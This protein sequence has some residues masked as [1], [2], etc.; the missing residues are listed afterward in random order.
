MPSIHHHPDA[1]WH[2]WD[3]HKNTISVAVLHPG[4]EVPATDKISHDEPSV[5]RLIARCGDPRLLRVCYEPA[6][7]APPRGH[8]LLTG[9][10]VHCDVIAPSLIPK[11]PGDRVKTDKRD[12]RR[13]VRLYRAGELTAIRVPT[14]AEEAVRDLLLA[15][16]DL[17]ADR[18]RARQRLGSF[19]PRH[20]RVWRAG[21]A[22]TR[23]HAAW[24][25]AQRF[26]EPALTAAFD[27]YRAVLAVR[28]AAAAITADLTAWYG[29]Q[30][31]ADTVHRLG[32]YRGIT[33]LGG[34]TLACEVC[35]WRRFS[36]AGVF[37]GFV[38]LVPSEYSSGSS[39]CRRCVDQSRQHP[40]PHPARRVPGVGLGL[41]APPRH[42]RDPAPPPRRRG[43]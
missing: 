41:S 31:F 43:S 30:P 14:P 4:Q 26:D 20:A 33:H 22:W 2:G 9:M 39:T 35:D 24:L 25:G 42:R 15:R 32:A 37:M 11:A 34:L 7:P 5:R 40:C 16:A 10:G 19:L 18:R 29:R 17:V 38:G 1:V 28:D 21:T 12:S 13:L 36:R 3:V 23:A 27:H 8:R 6:P